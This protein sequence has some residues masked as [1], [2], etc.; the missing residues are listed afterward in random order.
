[1]RV[2]TTIFLFLFA[3]TAVAQSDPA[4]I[5]GTIADQEG[6]ALSDAPVRVVNAETGADA[7]TYSSSDGH[8]ETSGLTTGNYTISVAMPCC[9]FKHYTSET[10][11][12]QEGQSLKFDVALEETGYLIA[13][14]DDPGS[15]AQEMRQR[16]VI[17]DKPLPRTHG[18]PV[19]S[20]V[21]LMN[22]D[23]FPEDP[24]PLSW[25]EQVAKQ[26]DPNNLQEDPIARC[27][28]G[29]LPIPGAA[30][31][32]ITRFVHTDDLLVMLFEGPPGFRLVFLDGRAHPETPN[33]SWLGHSI[34]R[35]EGDTLVVATVG[36]NTSGLSGDYP[37]SEMMRL[38]ERYARR[39]YGYMDLRLT[40]DDPGVFEQPWVR[41]LRF[42]LVPQ[43]ELIE[44]VCENNVW[45]QDG[46]E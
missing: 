28:P 25:A 31:P 45:I 2:F 14:A 27:L 30:I 24:Q 34:G 40:I 23:P 46:E 41:N 22:D 20:G 42:D 35:W 5:F 11:A 8:Y 37:R 26:R 3:F 7:R 39:E 13:L 12:L 21:W 19:L 6:A 15:L 38:E 29:E 32:M 43:E 4:S 33:P 16:R 36:F 17:P 1:M 18:K 10:V 44:F 9:T